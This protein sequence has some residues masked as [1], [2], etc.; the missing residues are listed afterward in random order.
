MSQRVYMENDLL[1]IDLFSTVTKDDIKSALKEVEALES[2]RPVTP[3]RL[4]DMTGWVASEN[5]FPEIF[6]LANERKKRQFNNAVKSAMV[7]PTPVT[8]GIA[9]MFQTVNDHPQITIQIFPDMA[10]ARAWLAET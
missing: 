6:S 7:A 8:L 4:T 2:T 3:H 10:A 5:R 1:R 9:R